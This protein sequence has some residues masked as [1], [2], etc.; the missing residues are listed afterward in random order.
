MLGTSLARP[1][2]TKTLV[3]PRPCSSLRVWVSRYSALSASACR[4]LLSIKRPNP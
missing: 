4:L 3:L 1:C 2:I